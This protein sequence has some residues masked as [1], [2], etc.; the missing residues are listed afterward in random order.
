MG[1]KDVKS[2]PHICC[3]NLDNVDRGGS[4]DETQPN[5]TEE[6]SNIYEDHIGG[7]EDE[8]EAEEVAGTGDNHERDPATKVM[9]ARTSQETATET[10]KGEESGCGQEVDP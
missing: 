8:E 3:G 7:K 5:A 1:L 9:E 10:S 4:K 2:H 6:P